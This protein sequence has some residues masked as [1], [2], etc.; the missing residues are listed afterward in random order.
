MYVA[1]SPTM[2]RIQWVWPSGGGSAPG[3]PYVPVYA[4]QA[5]C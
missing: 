5:A 3:F 1:S 4:A 2:V